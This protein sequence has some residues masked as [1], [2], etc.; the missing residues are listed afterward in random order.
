MCAGHRWLPHVPLSMLMMPF[1]CFWG[2]GQFLASQAEDRVDGLQDLRPLGNDQIARQIV[3]LKVNK[4][5]PAWFFLFVFFCLQHSGNVQA[6]S[7]TCNKAFCPG[8]TTE[9]MRGSVLCPGCQQP[10]RAAEPGL[11][12]T[13]PREAAPPAFWGAWEAVPASHVHFALFHSHN[14]AP[15]HRNTGL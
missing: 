7:A 11:P 6:L 10:Q 3:H 8:A 5:L 4:K 12:H 15:I 13:L 1:A 14:G 2:A 9:A